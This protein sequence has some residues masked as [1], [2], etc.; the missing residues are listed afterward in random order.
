MS[1]PPQ[2]TDRDLRCLVD[3]L[4]CVCVADARISRAEFSVLLEALKAAGVHGTEHELRARV[5]ARCREIH[6][7]GVRKTAEATIAAVRSAGNPQ[8][9]NLICRLQAS[10]LST[11][12][13]VTDRESEVARL[14]RDAFHAETRCQDATP[15]GGQATEPEIRQPQGGIGVSRVTLWMM[16]LLAVTLLFFGTLIGLGVRDTTRHAQQIRISAANREIQAA[17][18]KAYEWVRDGRL[19]DADRVE[20][21]LLDAKKPSFADNVDLLDPALTAVREAKGR[22]QAA[23]LFSEAQKAVSDRNLPAAQDL[24]EQYVAHASVTPDEVARAQEL[25]AEIE[26]STS[27]SEALRTLLAMDDS[28]FAEA[29]RSGVFSNA[30]LTDPVLTK[31]YITTLMKQVPEATRQREQIRRTRELVRAGADAKQAPD[32]FVQVRT[33]QEALKV[34]ENPKEYVGK[35][36]VVAGDIV[37]ILGNDFRRHKETD[38]YIFSWKCGKT[39]RGAEDFGDYTLLMDGVLNYWCDTDTGILAKEKLKSP[40]DADFVTY[41]M[42]TMTF[43]I[44]TK[45]VNRGELEKEYYIAELISMEPK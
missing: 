23:V 7:A 36:V 40:L 8:L 41:H 15:P 22:R 1:H 6:K 24:L 27:E 37:F 26:L 45:K 43:D 42:M 20:R 3:A 18:D 19:A 32:A 34:H 30:G 25:I 39:A 38:G 44:R 33:V 21:L 9:G 29:A 17:V 5:E 13:R 12:G 16:G 11:D 10:A 35:R 14:F 4:C 28:A 2:L 31:V